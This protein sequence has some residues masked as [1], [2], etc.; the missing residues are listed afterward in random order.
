MTIFDFFFCVF[1]LNTH[2]EQ[3]QK[4]NIKGEITTNKW[5]QTIHKRTKHTQRDTNYI[6]MQSASLQHSSHADCRDNDCAYRPQ[7]LHTKS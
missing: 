4:T 6:I 2:S 3:T 7:F 5:R 1:T